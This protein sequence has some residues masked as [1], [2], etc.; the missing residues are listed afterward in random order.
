MVILVCCGGGWGEL[1]DGGAFGGA[2]VAFGVEAEHPSQLGRGNPVAI[3]YEHH[4]NWQ[5]LGMAVGGAA[6]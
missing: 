6:A 2:F 5:R 4:A 1:V 3:T